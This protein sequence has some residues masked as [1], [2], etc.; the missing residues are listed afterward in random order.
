V[1]FLDWALTDGQKATS[2]LHYAP[3]PPA[4]A[5]KAKASL[6]KITDSGGAALLG[7]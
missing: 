5:T 2:A 4:V 1:K 3:L 6:A 7:H